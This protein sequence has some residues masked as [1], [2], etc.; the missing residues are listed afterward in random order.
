[1]EIKIHWAT[2]LLPLWAVPTLQEIISEPH[3]IIIIING[4]H[5][6]WDVYMI[7]RYLILA[8]KP[9]IAQMDTDLF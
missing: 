8:V 5:R 1:M 2:P 6:E 3:S 4:V 9:Y 7:T